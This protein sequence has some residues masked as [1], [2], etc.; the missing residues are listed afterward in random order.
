MRRQL[1]PDNWEE[2]SATVREASGGRCECEGECGKNHGD[3]NFAIGLRALKRC[4]EFNGML[5]KFA[6]GKIVLTAA[7]LC[8]HPECT[9]LDHLKSFCQRCHLRYDN[10]IKMRKLKSKRLRQSGQLEF[11]KK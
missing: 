9:D 2:I 6:R 11:L 3:E 8:H 10:M 4:F 5:A 1:Y 7:H